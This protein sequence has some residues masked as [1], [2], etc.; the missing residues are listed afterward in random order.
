M[1]SAPQTI[2]LRHGTTRQRAEAILIGGPDPNFREPG[3]LTRAEAF[4]TAPLGSRGQL[5]DPETVARRKAR[6]FEDEG[7]PVIVEI[8]VPVDVVA[9]ADDYGDEVR[10]GPGFGLEELLAAWPTIHKRLIDVTP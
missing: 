9:C 2:A 3:E 10:F 6:L 1:A 7:G 5:G 8:H 4:S